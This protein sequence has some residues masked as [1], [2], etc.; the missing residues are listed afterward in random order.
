MHE[1]TSLY[2]LH[3][4]MHLREN[5]VKV[6][7]DTHRRVVENGNYFSEAGRIYIGGGIPDD[8]AEL[9][10]ANIDEQLNLSVEWVDTINVAYQ[11]I[12]NKED[13]EDQL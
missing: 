12:C 7:V 11:E 9:I 6:L 10:R 2:L 1:A 5:S 13:E 8:V 3:V 4:V